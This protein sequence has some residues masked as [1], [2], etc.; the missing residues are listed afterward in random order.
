MTLGKTLG[1]QIQLRIQH[2]SCIV[3]TLIVRLE[4]P[5]AT[6]PRRGSTLAAGLELFAVEDGSI[7]CDDVTQKVNIGILMA[8]P[9]GAYGHIADRSGLAFRAAKSC[10]GVIDADYQW[11]FQCYVA[12]PR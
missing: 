5:R 2:D 1:W 7:R 11:G 10:G 3:M 6:L 9:K 4:H 8:H 12:L